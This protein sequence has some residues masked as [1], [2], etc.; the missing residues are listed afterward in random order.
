MGELRWSWVRCDC[1]VTPPTDKAWTRWSHPSNDIRCWLTYGGVG[2]SAGARVSRR[3]WS[4][5]AQALVRGLQSFR[6][7][8]EASHFRRWFECKSPLHNLPVYVKP[9]G[10]SHFQFRRIWPELCEASSDVLIIRPADWISLWPAI[11]YCSAHPWV[12]SSK[13]RNPRTDLWRL[14]DCYLRFSV[15]QKCW[16]IL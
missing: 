9:K 11:D 10:T 16:R 13:N 3:S 12:P 8:W 5:N 15:F 14:L 1:T 7:R 2:S 6:P 4:I